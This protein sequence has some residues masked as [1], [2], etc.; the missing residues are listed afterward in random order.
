MNSGKPGRPKK[1]H[2]DLKVKKITVRLEGRDLDYIH[3]M[4]KETDQANDSEAVRQIIRD[5]RAWIEGDLVVLP[6]SQDMRDAIDPIAT[7]SGFSKDVTVQMLVFIGLEGLRHL[8]S[9][10][11]VVR[12][13]AE[14]NGHVR[15]K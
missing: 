2:K 5:H 9:P 14:E 10:Y 7:V 3:H 1:A 15:Q 6:L 12:R 11:K 13:L 8:K 4:A